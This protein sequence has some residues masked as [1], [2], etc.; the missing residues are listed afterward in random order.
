MAEENVVKEVEEIGLGK[1][2]A[3]NRQKWHGAVN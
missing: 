2:D 3:F 1:E